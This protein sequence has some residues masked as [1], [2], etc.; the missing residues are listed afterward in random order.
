MSCKKQYNNKVNDKICQD[1]ERA[2]HDTKGDLFFQE[3]RRR[4]PYNPQKVEK[5]HLI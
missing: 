3:R 1:L 5:H 4:G 2:I